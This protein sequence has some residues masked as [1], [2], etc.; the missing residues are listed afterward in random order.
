MLLHI[1]TW[2]KVADL[3]F[4]AIL[5]IVVKIC[6]IPQTKFTKEFLMKIRPAIHAAVLFT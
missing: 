5:E 2:Y 6:H 3:M 1:N 4:R